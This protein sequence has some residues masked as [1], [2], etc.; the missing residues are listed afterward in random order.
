VVC[1]SVAAVLVPVVPGIGAFGS[2]GNGETTS[3]EN[4]LAAP[5]CSSDSTELCLKTQAIVRTETSAVRAFNV[6]ASLSSDTGATAVQPVVTPTPAP[7]PTAEP[8]ATM[9]VREGDTL[10]ALADWFGLSP[11]DIAVANGAAVD[12]YLVIGATIAIPIPAS[13]FV[14]PPA[15]DIYVAEAPQPEPEAPA[16]APAVIVPAT[17]APTP[18]PAQTTWTTDEVIAAICSLPWPCDQM[19]K[20]A[21]CESGLNPNAYN[22]AGYYGL[23]QINYSFDGWND[24]YVNASVAY[25]VKYL[26]ALAHGDGLSPWPVCRYY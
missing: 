22:P 8:W 20:I 24:P 3:R 14:M 17:P 5:A 19:V 4:V 10:I 7:E 16:P 18:P 26:P 21:S 6:T 23:F 12:D 25:T 13:Q 11:F 2:S 15:P 9:E 1:L